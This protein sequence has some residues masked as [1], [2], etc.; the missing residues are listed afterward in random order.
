MNSHALLPIEVMQE[1]HMY[2]MCIVCERRSFSILSCFTHRVFFLKNLVELT[3][4]EHWT[5]PYLPNMRK[6]FILKTSTSHKLKIPTSSLLSFLAWSKN[7]N[8]VLVGVAGTT[9][10]LQTEPYEKFENQT[11]KSNALPLRHRTAC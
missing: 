1:M 7:E 3:T 4:N 2:F 5:L 8:I 10:G 9:F 6:K 11:Y